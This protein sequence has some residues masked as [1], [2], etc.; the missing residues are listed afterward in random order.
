[1]S[2]AGPTQAASAK[3]LALKSELRCVHFGGCSGCT[4]EAGLAK[5]PVMEDAKLF[6]ERLLPEGQGFQIHMG[7]IHRW[8]TLA[9]LAV[10][11]SGSGNVE[12]GLY[13]AGSH[14][15]LGIPKCRVHH[16]SINDAVEV[17]QREMLDQGV[18]GYNEMTDVGHV[19]YVQ[20][21]VERHSNRVQLTLV[22]NA[23]NFRAASPTAQRLVKKLKLYPMFH[24]I[25]LNFRTGTG[26]VIF[27][28]KVSA[29]HLAHGPPNVLETILPQRSNLT[30][31][32]APTMF[33]QVSR[34]TSW[35]HPDPLP[36]PEHPT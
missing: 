17:L 4:S 12:I 23:D 33:R 18:A 20:M 34:A 25:W 10:A 2:A 3:E 15:V 16:P 30:F 31:P 26:N 24:S 5:T 6:F 21:M 19:R 32:V 9:K 22:W 29:W 27:N 8:R 11:P 14:D 1:M 7:K 13:Q 35:L 36:A 28:R